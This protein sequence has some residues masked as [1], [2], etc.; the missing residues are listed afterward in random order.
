[1][2]GGAG[3]RGCEAAEYPHEASAHE[4]QELGELGGLKLP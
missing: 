2:I 3:M 4:G 1:M